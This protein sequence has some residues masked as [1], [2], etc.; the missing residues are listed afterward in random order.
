LSHF[1][2]IVNTNNECVLD[3]RELLDADDEDCIIKA[4][5]NA[6]YDATFC[7][8]EIVWNST[9]ADWNGGRFYLCGNIA[10]VL[11]GYGVIKTK[12]DGNCGV[13]ALA[14]ESKPFPSST[15][16]EAA[17]ELREKL[18]DV[19]DKTLETET[20]KAVAANKEAIED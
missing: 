4:A 12:D 2:L 9:F 10:L 15:E 5:L 3:S 8:V 16:I 13:E 20:A 7:V 11:D 17:F 14:N 19:Y 1:S 18:A 6:V